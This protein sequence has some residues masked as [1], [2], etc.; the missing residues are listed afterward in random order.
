MRLRWVVVL[1]AGGGA[2]DGGYVD[3]EAVEA[4]AAAMGDPEA[5][6]L[7][8]PD[9]YALQF[10]VEAPTPSAALQQAEQRWHGALVGVAVPPWP[11]ARTE[12]LRPDGLALFELGPGD[13]P[14]LTAA[15]DDVAAAVREVTSGLMVARSQVQV[16][17]LL[18][19]FV[20]RLGGQHIDRGA[21][22]PD[23]I[24]LDLDLSAGIEVGSVVAEPLSLSRLHLEETLPGVLEDAR[25]V[26]RRLAADAPSMPAR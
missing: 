20:H 18:V 2:H 23:A 5:I 7:Y 3:I 1:E 13:L 6:A 16:V 24:P 11:L 17:H 4:L 19:R 25:R 21:A 9:C 14:V 22:G 8:S 15:D 26:L 10:T 12:V